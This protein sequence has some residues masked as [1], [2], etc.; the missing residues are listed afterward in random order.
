MDLSEK[1][2]RYLY[3]LLHDHPNLSHLA[4]RHKIPQ[5]TVSNVASLGKTI[6]MTPETLARFAAAVGMAPWKLMRNAMAFADDGLIP[7]HVF[8]EL[9][10]SDLIDL[11]VSLRTSPSPHL[12][13]LYQHIYA[14]IPPEKL[15]R[16]DAALRKRLG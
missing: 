3:H 1:I 11:L 4:S 15:D 2:C 8:L 9:P 13:E 10:E 6:K 12:K 14:G 7:I 16:L 5:A